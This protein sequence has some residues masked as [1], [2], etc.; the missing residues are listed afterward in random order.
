MEIDR[1]SILMDDDH[2]K[3]LGTYAAKIKLYKDVVVPLNFEV[4]SE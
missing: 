4:V 2:V 3:A 1:K